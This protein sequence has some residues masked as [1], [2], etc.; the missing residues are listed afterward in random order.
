MST[1]ASRSQL[2]KLGITN[3][4]EATRYA[5]RNGLID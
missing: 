1:D 2:T 3:R 4:T 5:H